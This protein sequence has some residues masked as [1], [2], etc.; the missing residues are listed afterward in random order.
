MYQLVLAR[1][2][3]FSTGSQ[4]DLAQWGGGGGHLSQETWPSAWL[5]K[6]QGQLD[7]VE[8]KN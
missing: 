8:E 2:G 1:L 4:L 5:M 6:T 3:F 7:P